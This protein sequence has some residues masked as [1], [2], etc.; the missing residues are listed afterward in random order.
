MIVIQANNFPQYSIAAGAVFE[1]LFLPPDGTR[2]RFPI[3]WLG[4]GRYTTGTLR[5]W[6]NGI[7][8]A[9]NVDFT[10][11]ENGVFFQ[12]T[13]A[14]T[15]NFMEY[16]V[17]YMPRTAD[18]VFATS[19]DEMFL[20]PNWLGAPGIGDAFWI[21]RHLASRNDASNTAAGSS[22]IP[23]SRKGVV[24]WCS[25]D[26]AT[27]KSACFAKGSGW[28]IVQNREWTNIARWCKLMGIYPTGNSASGVDGMGVA[29]APDPTQSGRALTSTGP[30]TSS[31]NLLP[32]GI[33]DLVGNVWEW[34]DGVQLQSGVLWVFDS[35]NALVSTGI[36]PTFGTS[37][38]AY[39]Y[40]RTDASLVNECI[41]AST[42]ESY[43]GNDGFWFNT[44]GVMQ[45]IR[46]GSWGYGFLGGLFAF[47]VSNAP[48][49]VSTF[50]GFRLAKSM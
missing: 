16:V 48:S 33:Y 42:G 23:S 22:N 14:P 45:L 10:E 34:I 46:G 40:L 31:H 9:P 27:A 29:H 11:E 44:S 19:I 25:V 13:T 12:F 37:A 7:S 28:H 30:I 4:L 47:S 24:P 18:K 35:N 36:N 8:L 32:G 38:S 26:F 5:M 6:R 15:G 17:S 1:P 41:P 20:F 21:G 49:Y 43:K 3:G 39:S 2:T 50:I